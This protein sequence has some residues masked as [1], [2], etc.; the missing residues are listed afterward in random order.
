MRRAA[1]VTGGSRGIGAAIVRELCESGVDVVYTSTASDDLGDDL[2]RKFAVDCR[3]IVFDQASDHARFLPARARDML[4]RLDVVVVNAGMSAWAPLDGGG[5][6]SL[7]D[8]QFDVNV[9]GSFAILR[10]AA[11]IVA[12]DGRIVVIGSTA[13]NHVEIPGLADYAAGKAALAAF[14]RGAARDLGRRGVTVNCVQPGHVATRM[15][16]PTEEAL[17]RVGERS[18][19]GRFGRPEEIASVVAFLAGEGASYMT[20]AVVDVD[21]GAGA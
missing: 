2:S 14:V 9:R 13:A 21:G 20:G 18:A 19:L 11:E 4:G 3:N 16:P 15:N 8:R 5:E 7:L 10:G 17:R 12:D 1:L 6:A